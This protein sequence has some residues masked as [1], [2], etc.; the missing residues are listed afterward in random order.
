M[1]GSLDTWEAPNW[2]GGEQM[3]EWNHPKIHQTN[4]SCI[5]RLRTRLYVTPQINSLVHWTVALSTGRHEGEGEAMAGSTEEW[6]RYERWN[7]A[8]ATVVF[9]PVH[10]GRPVYLDLEEDILRDVQLDAEP[11]AA[12]SSEALVDAVKG[13]L[14]LRHGASYVL[15]GHLQR[16]NHWY[17]GPMLDPPPCLGL[18]SILSLTAERMRH[19]EGMKAHNFYGRLGELLHLDKEQIGW[20]ESAYRQQLGGG[21]A[22]MILWESLND[23]LEMMEGSRGLPTVQPIGHSH[24][25]LPL[26]QALV[27]QADREKFSHLF[28]TQG[29]VAG[30]SMATNEMSIQI[31][32]WLARVPCPASHTLEQLW[33]Q[34]P[35]S[36]E[37]IAEN[38]C[39]SLA[40]WDGVLPEGVLKGS[41]QREIDSVRLKAGLWAFPRRRVELSMLVP[42]RATDEVE[43]LDVLGP[44]G[45]PVSRV[46]M[47]PVASGWMGVG[48]GSDIDVASFLEGQVRLQRKDQSLPLRRRP[49]RLVVLRWD[50]LL[51]AFVENERVQLGEESLVLSR[52]EIA[53]GVERFLVK[54]ARPGF[55]RTS[56]LEGLPVG[57]TLFEGV[58]VLSFVERDPRKDAV[59]LTALQPMVR[60]Q[61]VLQGGLRLPGYQRKW[62]TARPPELR[63]SVDDGDQLVAIL[64]CRRPLVQPAPAELMS[65]ATGSVL[66]WDLAEENLPDGD[67]EIMIRSDS[68]LVG[69]ELLR[70]RSAD[71]PALQTAD[72][73]GL[74]ALDP[75]SVGFGITATRS[76]SPFA[77]E[78]APDSGRDPEPSELPSV[79]GWW[80]ARN[81]DTAPH[82]ARQVI[83]FPSGNSPCIETG[84]HHM[85]LPTAMVGQTSIDGVCRD[86][87]LVKRLPAWR[88]RVK[89]K[90]NE[91]EV[92]R[93]V[94]NMAD[95]PPVRTER[96]IDWAVAFD[97]VC[98][99]GAGT[100]SDLGRI[101][102]QMEATDLFGDTFARRLEMLGHI[103][104]ERN[105][106]TLAGVS[107]QVN[108]PTIIGLPSGELAV[109]GFRSE[110]TMVAIE[111]ELYASGNEPM[112][113]KEVIGPPLVLLRGVSADDVK[114]ITNAVAV[115]AERPARHV[116]EAAANL[117][118]LLPPFSNVA[119]NLPRTRMINARSYEAWNTESA[120]FMPAADAGSAGAYR[121]VGFARVYIYRRPEDL[122]TME[123]VLGDARIVKYLAALDA[124]SGLVGYDAEEQVLYVPLGADLPGLYGRAAVLASGRPPLENPDEGILQYGNVPPAMAGHLAH[125]LMS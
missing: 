92:V 61:V 94:L 47:V 97:A 54:A 23:W 124:R 98:H 103:E 32:E 69:S 116:P 113:E 121:L 36:H 21:A 51:Q 33:R 120:R 58:Q 107:W 60:S 85:I 68:N 5:R 1:A 79:P 37:A 45:E 102:N 72:S 108:D 41:V 80:K 13:T 87:G 95:L 62:L 112:R 70:L 43:V 8:I 104:I 18:L 111:D 118:S 117:A 14:V 52:S 123:A 125:L 96:D 15:D 22:S 86:C 4:S 105:L 12:E 64:K 10:A 66:L 78:C 49:R 101:T 100:I 93:P 119:Q 75:A 115:A 39:Q 50:D 28:A 91:P 17:E 77:F 57:W 11:D 30:S 56:D 59:D 90:R 82:A 83:R 48:G 106:K 110:R 24:I 53:G 31:D 55:R 27:R 25:G 42:G 65:E 114:Q 40:D 71:N 99:V 34:F 122:G 76:S 20:F 29:L 7:H 26:S 19:G 44:D 3:P 63:A 81:R 6:A 74:L 46:D 35:E 109:T 9:S 73:E 38:A 88:G 16:L 84:A 2:L 67:Y 89:K